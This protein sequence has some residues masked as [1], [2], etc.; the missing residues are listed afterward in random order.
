ML[1]PE[2]VNGVVGRII[3][4]HE[5]GEEVVKMFGGASFHTH[6]STVPRL[7]LEWTSTQRWE[8][9]RVK[10]SRVNDWRSLCFYDS[11]KYFPSRSLFSFCFVQHLVPNVSSQL[12]S[13]TQIPAEWDKVKR[14]EKTGSG[15]VRGDGMQVFSHVTTWGGGQGWTTWLWPVHVSVS[16]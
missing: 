15:V 10:G 9:M 16:S 3:K 5:K 13:R 4:W 11:Y 2:C 7:S 6:P 8:V 1:L 12:Y 14:K